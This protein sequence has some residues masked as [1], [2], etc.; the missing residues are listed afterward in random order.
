AAVAGVPLTHREHAQA[1]TLV[2]GEGSEGE[3]DLDWASLA[4]LRQTLVIYMGV[5]AAGRI[6]ARLI[7]HGL[8]PATPAAIVENGTLRDERTVTGRV[9]DLE[10]LVREHGIQGP[11]VIVVG[12]VAALADAASIDEPALAVAV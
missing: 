9:A 7:G 2:T 6:A 3:P 1:V 4:R 11:A 8:D 12:S 5:A 10:S